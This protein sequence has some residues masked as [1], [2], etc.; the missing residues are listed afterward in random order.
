M[1]NVSMRTKMCLKPAIF[2]LFQ[3]GSPHPRFPLWGKRR[4]RRLNFDRTVLLPWENDVSRRR[5]LMIQLPRRGV[6]PSPWG[7]HKSKAASHMCPVLARR[8]PHTA[9]VQKKKEGEKLRHLLLLLG[10]NRGRSRGKCEDWSF[11]SSFFSEKMNLREKGVSH[12]GD[13]S[14]LICPNFGA[15][16]KGKWYFS[17]SLKPRNGKGKAPHDLFFWPQR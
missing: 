1:R 14:L 16:R 11:S 4:R 12:V 2:F 13:I 6:L 15:N 7:H 9:H 8:Y 5:V 17:F 10:G 3:S